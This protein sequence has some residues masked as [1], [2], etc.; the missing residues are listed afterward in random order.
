MTRSSRS[1]PVAEAS[2][3]MRAMN[4]PDIKPA[5]RWYRALLTRTPRGRKLRRRVALVI[6][7]LTSW[8]WIPQLLGF[9][10]RRFAARHLGYRPPG[11]CHRGSDC[12]MP[13]EF[14]HA[15]CSP[16]GAPSA[17]TRGV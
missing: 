16:A 15:Y 13:C 9:S 17:P 1:T 8:F 7:I 2:G 14:A 3:I 6:V 10:P 4:D 5:V 11:E 12:D